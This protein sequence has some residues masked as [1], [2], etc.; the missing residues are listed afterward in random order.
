M[1]SLDLYSTCLATASIVLQVVV[2]CVLWPYLKNQRAIG[3]KAKEDSEVNRV[4]NRLRE[5][6]KGEEG[7]LDRDDLRGLLGLG[8]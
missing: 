7:V 6:A 3:I 8:E 5:K 2:V 1:M 4:L